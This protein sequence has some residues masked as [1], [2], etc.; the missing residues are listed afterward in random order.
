VVVDD[1]SAAHLRGE[2]PP[3][4]GSNVR[5]RDLRFTRNRGAQAA[6][7]LG[8]RRARFSHVAFLDSDDVFLPGK[9]DAVLR[10]LEGAAPDI[11]FHAVQGMARY[12]RLARCWEHGARGLLPFHWLLA[13]VN[14]IPTPA[15]VVRRQRRL[16]P[17]GLRH[18]EDWAFLL[19]YA[20]PGQRV[21]Y[22]DQTFAAVQ[23]PAGSAGGLSGAAWRMRRGEFSARRVLLKSPSPGQLLRFAAGSIAGALR[24]LADL[25]R[26]RY[27]R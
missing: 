25:L 5:L 10:Q 21:V 14:P 19:R 22:L 11:L 16:G 7:N 17:P 27:W 4:N 12:A 26:G 1:G 2:L 20:R 3:R 15:L 13:L 6:R 18:S 9:I 24:V 23:R 8:L